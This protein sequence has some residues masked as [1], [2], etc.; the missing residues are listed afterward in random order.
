MKTWSGKRFWEIDVK[1]I[2]ATPVQEDFEDFVAWQLDKKGMFSVKSAYKI[3]VNIRDG[4]QA[5]SSNN[6]TE[7]FQWSKIWKI[8]CVPKIQQFI[9]SSGQTQH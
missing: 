2:L 6:A 7:G 8:P 5:T 9:W 4:P 3:Y 1:T